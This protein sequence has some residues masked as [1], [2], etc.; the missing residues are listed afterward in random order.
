MKFWRCHGFQ[1]GVTKRKFRQVC[2]GHGGVSIW[3]EFYSNRLAM[4]NLSPQS[5]SQWILHHP[6]I[7]TQSRPSVCIKFDRT[8]RMC[9]AMPHISTFGLLVHIP[10]SISTNTMWHC[11]SDFISRFSIIWPAG[12]HPWEHLNEY[13]T[14]SLLPSGG[15]HWCI[16]ITIN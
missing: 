12:P 1:S 2:H 16:F 8:T 13:S 10:W 5:I 9:V 15:N 11:F 7:A 6:T 3:F 14:H 4:Q